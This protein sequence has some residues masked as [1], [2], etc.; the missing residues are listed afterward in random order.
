[1]RLWAESVSF[2]CSANMSNVHQSVFAEYQ[3][4]K[5][6]ELEFSEE[7]PTTKYEFGDEI[8]RLASKI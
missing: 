4:S 2:P 1:M 7:N 5:D 3:R 8:G 6:V